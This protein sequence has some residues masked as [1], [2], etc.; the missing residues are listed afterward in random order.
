MMTVGSDMDVMTRRKAATSANDAPTEKTAADRFANPDFQAMLAIC[1]KCRHIGSIESR[2]PSLIPARNPYR[3]ILRRDYPE[4]FI[5]LLAFVLGIWLW[6]HYFGESEGYAPGTEEIALVKIDRDLRLADAMSGD[7]GWLRWMAGAE[8][9]AIVRETAL[10]ALEKLAADGSMG[11]AGLEAYAIVKSEHE[12]APMRQVLA[13][14]MQGQVMTDFAEVS[15]ELARHGGTWW[16]ARRVA[17][18]ETEM[19]PAAEWRSSFE[20]DSRQLRSRAILARSWVWLLGLAGVAFIPRTLKLLF[21]GLGAR[22]KG[23]SAAW[24]LPLGMV[25]FLVSTLAWIG[26]TLT[27]DIGIGTLPG[28]HPLAGILLDSAARLLP[29]LIAL[30]LLFRRPSHAMRVLGLGPSLAPA[31]ILG[32]FSLLM[33]VDLLLRGVIGGGDP[34]E[35]GGGLSAGEAGL[36]GL[37]FAVVSA[38]LLAP[39]AEEILYRGVLFRS[40]WT[41]LGVLP[42]AVLSSAVFAVLHFYDGYGLASVGVFGFACALLYAAT[43][44]LTSCVALHLLYNSAIILPEWWFYHGA[45]G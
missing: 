28:L 17:E 36:W 12:G 39:L 33:I 23:Y 6:D 41:R 13:E 3:A 11:V 44:S 14:T 30:G 15:R 37:A 9:P 32:M 19:T 18:L 34:T 38:C 45:L 25:V 1:R 8:D 31:A 2:Q 27:L 26:F 7:P 21:R 5:A 16:H 35:P 40:L 24:P 22:P 20:A 4:P 43:G 10:I 29:A 42:A